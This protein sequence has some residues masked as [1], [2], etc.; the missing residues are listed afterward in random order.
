MDN[1][2]H[3]LMTPPDVGAVARL[4]Q[5][6]GRAYV[7]QFNARH[8][9]TGTLREGRYKACLVDS[10]NYVLHCHRYIDLNPVRARMTDDPAAYPWSNCPSHC[11]HRADAILTPHPTYAALGVTPEARAE[12]HRHLLHETLSD[13]DLTA[14]R[15]RWR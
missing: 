9:R 8:R 5:K 14:I 11:G 3:Q 7:S 13:D 1:H 6:L 4:M 2:V 12:A 15:S 10:E